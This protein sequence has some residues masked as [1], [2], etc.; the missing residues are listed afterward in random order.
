MSVPVLLVHGLW[1]SAAQMAPLK[2][3]LARH[4][5]RCHAMDLVPN[6]GRAPI[7]DLGAQVARDAEAL[8]AREGTAQIDLV[9]FSM[10]ALA[11]R[12]FV[13]RGG[14]AARVRRFVSI[15]GPHHGTVT[16]YAL[17]FAGIRDMRPKSAL[18][19]DLASDADPFGPVE[20]HCTYTP[21]D[22]MIVPATSGAL[23]SARSVRVFCVPTH[24]RMIKSGRVIE[25]A[26]SVLLQ[27][28][29]FSHTR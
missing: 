25:Y 26:T 22:L 18:L 27:A 29:E 17:P 15:S 12:W 23:P 14:G 13:Q 1:H 7:A 20:V 5:A 16:A 6:D 8:C 9:G 21:F 28:E 10:G 11:S 2:A 24:E 3:A 19:R 4:G